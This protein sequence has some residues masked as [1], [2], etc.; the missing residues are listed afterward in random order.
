M[1]RDAAQHAAMHLVKHA[2]LTWMVRPAMRWREAEGEVE[3]PESGDGGG[4][5]EDGEEEG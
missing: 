1:N 2:A 3:V 5:R 4:G